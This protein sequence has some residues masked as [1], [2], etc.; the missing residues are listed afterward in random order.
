MIKNRDKI[1]EYLKNNKQATPGDISRYLKI[2]RSAT[3]RQIK[4]LLEDGVLDKIGKSPKVFYMLKNESEVL[5]KSNIDGKLKE[6]IDENFMIITADGNRKEGVEAFVDWCKDRNENVEKSAIEYV[7]TFDKY[8]AYKKD[9]II[10]GNYKIKKAFE[11]V[12][13]DDVFYLDFY[14]I[15]RFGKTKLGQLL[16]YAKQ[17][18]D[19]QMIEELNQ[20]IKPEIVSLIKKQ[21]V[22]AVGFIPPTVKRETQL[23]REIK[24]G[25]NL[26][27]PELN[28]VKVKTNVT[29]PQKTLNK[30]SHRIKNAEKTIFVDDNRKFNKVLLIDDAVGS[31]ST[32]N[33][34]AKKIKEQGISDNVIGLAVVGS[35]SGFEVISE[36]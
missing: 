7:K 14:A 36:V 13:L 12:Y 25:L 19:L 20:K 21:S 3:H 17:S 30:L 29:V 5:A 18:Q 22:D 4:R 2:N 10:N 1:I 34:T 9:G 26:S 32:L 16:L 27:L 23:M 28:L 11:S 6:T 31:G 8:S 15:E 35:F 33:E 24:K